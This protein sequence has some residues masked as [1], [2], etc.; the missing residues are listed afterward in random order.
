MVDEVVSHA[1][2]H[3]FHPEHSQRLAACWAESLGGR[4]RYSDC[5]SD[6]TSVVRIHSGNGPH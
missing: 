5:Y 2:S 6:E 1:F 3:G 4:T